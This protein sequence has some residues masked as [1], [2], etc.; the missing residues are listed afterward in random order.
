MA[1]PREKA[2]QAAWVAEDSQPGELRVLTVQIRGYL[3]TSWVLDEGTID[4]LGV[5]GE[6]R[7]RGIGRALLD[8]GLTALAGRGIRRAW[9]EV[10][11]SYE[12][13]IALYTA[14]GF[15]PIARR[16]GYYAGP[17]PDDALVMEKIIA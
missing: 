3:L 17:P 12:P 10:A 11:T 2:G 1:E 9:L 14:A 5:A 7:R 16:K 8:H 4:R 6:C 13:A 15:R